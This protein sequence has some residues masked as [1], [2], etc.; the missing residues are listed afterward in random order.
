ML[1]FYWSLGRDIVKKKAES[2]WESIFFDAVSEDLRKMIL[3]TKGFPT[4]NHRYMKRYYGMFG[5]ILT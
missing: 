4:T 5:I 1:R 2:K 3:G